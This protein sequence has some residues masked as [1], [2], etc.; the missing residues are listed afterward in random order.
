MNHQKTRISKAALS[1]RLPLAAL[2][3]LLLSACA[4]TGPQTPPVVDRAQE[5]WDALIAGDLEKAYTYYSPGYRSSTS[6]IDFG[7]SIRTRR[8][9][10]TSATYKDHSCEGERCIVR[11]DIGFRVPRP[12]PGLDVFDGK[13][14]AEDT[15]IRSQGQWWY[16]P[17]N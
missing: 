2:A 11:F 6:L 14:V 9:Q 10:W 5:R 15:W 8:V 12:V 17:N 3:V 4:A 13:D 7:V 1:L 16:V